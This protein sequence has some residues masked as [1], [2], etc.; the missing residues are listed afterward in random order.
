MG[1]ENFT[2]YKVTEEIVKGHIK[3]MPDLLINGGGQGGSG[4]LDGLLGM[5]IM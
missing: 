4:S 2:T 5:Q 3:I 1:Q